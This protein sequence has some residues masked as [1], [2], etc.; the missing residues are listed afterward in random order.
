[1]AKD[2]ADLFPG[3][4]PDDLV[5]QM[6]Q[7]FCMTFEYDILRRDT[8][9]FASRLEK[10]GKLAGICDM[11]GYDHGAFLDNTLDDSERFWKGFTDAF[12]ASTS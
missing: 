5:A 2:C 1:M 3:R 10:V 12:N 11:G 7:T 8:L 9:T 6:P 4:M